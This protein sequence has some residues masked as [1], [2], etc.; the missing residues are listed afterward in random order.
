[1]K[2][3]WTS[4]LISGGWR[5][6]V[7]MSVYNGV[8]WKVSEWKCFLQGKATSRH[9]LPVMTT[10]SNIANNSQNVPSQQI[11]VC[12]F[13]WHH[14][15]HHRQVDLAIGL[16]RIEYIREDRKNKRKERFPV[17]FTFLFLFLRNIFLFNTK[18]INCKWSL[19]NNDWWMTIFFLVCNSTS[20]RPIRCSY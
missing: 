12:T 19:S 8:Y 3:S 2:V 5:Q 9:L 4:V 16:L 10:L 11:D 7:W 1:M 18:I 17:T 6:L 20:I 13:S 14:T 15:I